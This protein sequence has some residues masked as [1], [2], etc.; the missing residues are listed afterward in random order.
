MI[1][2][3][4]G[5]SLLKAMPQGMG[6]RAQRDLEAMGVEMRLGSYVT[7]VDADGV[8]IGDDWVPAE[9]VL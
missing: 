2:V 9:N 3:E 7:S 6:K 4:G 8:M 5:D 1:L